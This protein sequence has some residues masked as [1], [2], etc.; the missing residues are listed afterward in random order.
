VRRDGERIEAAETPQEALNELGAFAQ[1]RCG[2]RTR[3][4]RPCL[5]RAIRV[6][7]CRN[8]GACSTGPRTPQG[9]L[10][11]LAN[12]KQFRAAK[13]ALSSGEQA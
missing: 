2:A 9:R 3:L 11:A 7:R 5:R 10:K 6:G 12:L 13:S 1:T 8:H 4:G